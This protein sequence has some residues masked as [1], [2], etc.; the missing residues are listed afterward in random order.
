MHRSPLCGD[1][2]G[3]ADNDPDEKYKVGLFLG[4]R[5]AGPD[6][7]MALAYVRSASDVNQME[8]VAFFSRYGEV[9][10][11]VA[12]FAEPTNTVAERIF[13]VYR[14]HAAAVCKVFDNGISAPYLPL[15]NEV[16]EIEPEIVNALTRIINLVDEKEDCS[17]RA[18][19][20]CHVKQLRFSS[21]FGSSSITARTGWTVA[22]GSGGQKVL[23]MSSGS[24]ELCHISR[25]HGLAARSRSR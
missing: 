18:I 2:R 24:L 12:F 23:R 21:C 13:D 6:R 14:R 17:N 20:P 8:D 16:A 1:R 11:A 22:S 15:T 7:E 10:C 25:G 9:S 19:Y 4:E 3:Q 5:Q